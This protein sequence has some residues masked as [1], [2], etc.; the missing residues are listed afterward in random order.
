MIAAATAAVAMTGWRID[1]VGNFS[2]RQAIYSVPATGGGRV[3]AVT[4][5]ERTDF[6]APLPS[7]DG[8]SILYRDAAGDIWAARANGG[9]AH[10]IWRA[11]GGISV[12]AAS[13]SPDSKHVAYIVTSLSQ[14]SVLHVVRADGTG[15]RAVRTFLT[16]GGG[17]YA[18]RW[19]RRGATV[20]VDG[21]VYQ[22]MFSGPGLEIVRRAT[23][24]VVAAIPCVCQ[25]SLWSPGTVAWSS[26]GRRLAYASSSAIAVFDLVAGRSRTLAH[27]RGT[28]LAWRPDG[29]ALAYTDDGGDIRT[30]TLHDRRVRLVARGGTPD[31]GVVTELA[32]SRAAPMAYDRPPARAGLYTISP[33]DALAADG[34][35]VVYHTCSDLRVWSPSAGTLTDRGT[36]SGCGSTDRV[37]SLA[38]GDAGLIY[39]TVGGG[40]NKRW[41]V[42]GDPLTSPRTALTQGNEL[43]CTSYPVAGGSGQTLVYADRVGDHRTHTWTIRVVGGPPLMTFEQNALV[44]VALD[45]ESDRV[46]VA[47]DGAIDVLRA[48]NGATLLHLDVAVDPTLLPYQRRPPEAK[49]AGDFVVLHSGDHLG[50]FAIGAHLAGGGVPVPADSTLQDARPGAVAYVERGEVY[51]LEIG[52]LGRTIAVAPGEFARFVDGGIAVANGARVQVVPFAG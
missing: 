15:D 4:N 42:L 38:V 35:R 2:G 39:S 40:N 28:R 37:T 6:R 23:G 8:R 26:D 11:A 43:C 22:V 46:L 52:G 17:P 13:W 34:S 50:F 16:T 41:S 21:G 19:T 32:W 10:Q 14:P 3:A 29:Q 24:S 49:L 27:E 12:G 7:P 36:P 20:A 33:V 47:R 48:E 25:E 30:V 18:P 45:V 51:V 1:F 44:D 5:D 31:V 9:D